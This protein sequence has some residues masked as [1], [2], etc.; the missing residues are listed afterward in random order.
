M[1]F[2][3]PYIEIEEK[4]IGPGCP[5][6]LIAEIGINH[7]GDIALAR[8]MIDS[9]VRAGADCVKFQT[10]RAEEF[11]ADRELTYEYESAGK[12]VKEKMYDMFKRMELPMNGYRELFEYARSKGVVPM[13]SV[14]DPESAM[15]IEEIGATALKLASEDLINLP[16]IEFVAKS[17]LPLILSTGMANK[18]EVLDALDILKKFNKKDIVLLHCVS[19][20]P[21]PED[22]ANLLRMNGLKELFDGPVGY[23]DH[24]RG[25]LAS[26]AA[27]AM[28]ACLIE[29]HYTLDKDLPGPD[30]ALSSDEAEFSQLVREVR[31]IEK[32]LGAKEIEPSRTERETKLL[33]RRSIVAAKSL[34]AGTLLSEECIALKRPGYG[35]RARES[36][37]ILGKRLKR[38]VKQDEQISVEDVEL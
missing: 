31:T 1:S 15:A 17:K 8:K 10:F 11:M 38:A 14:A 34:S 37:K 36:S 18:E 35:L 33:F 4:R 2:F 29:K 28:G 5:A 27:V 12:K 20:Y 26:V 23:S 32:M 3:Y 19:I 16:L 24:T 30:Q 7:N 22:E 25:A 21:T 13:T 6:F 9:A